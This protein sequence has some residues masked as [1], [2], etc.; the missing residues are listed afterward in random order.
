[1]KMMCDEIFG[2]VSAVTSFKQ[3]DMEGALQVA[4]NTR[5][6][7]NGGVFTEDRRKANYCVRKI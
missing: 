1:M 2:P 3:G 6:G 4:N 7:L 5:Y